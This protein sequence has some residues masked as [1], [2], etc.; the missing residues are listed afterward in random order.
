MLLFHGRNSYKGSAA[1]SQFVMQRGVTISVMQAIFSSIFY[2]ASISLYQGVLLVG[3]TTVYTMYAIASLVFDRDVRPEIALLYPELYK[4]L[5]K[6]RSLSLKTFVLWVFI[7]TYQGAAIM[8]GAFFIF[9]DDFIHVVSITF[10]ALLL[11]EL[12]MIA[13]TVC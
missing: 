11:T 8:Y 10:T 5:T 7:A 1:V 12:I 4:E 13:L 3:F 2:F 9:D 6:G